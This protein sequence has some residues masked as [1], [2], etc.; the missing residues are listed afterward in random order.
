[1][2]DWEKMRRQINAIDQF[3]GYL[4]DMEG[5]DRFEVSLSEGRY[6]QTSNPLLKDALDRAWDF[7]GGEQAAQAAV[8]GLTCNLNLL[9]IIYGHTGNPLFALYALKVCL[10]AELTPPVWIKEYMQKSV[11]RLLGYAHRDTRGKP[12]D[13]F[14]ESF[15]FRKRGG[16]SGGT[17]FHAFNV[18]LHQIDDV[19]TQMKHRHKN[20]NPSW[21]EA[22]KEIVSENGFKS[23]NENNPNAP[24]SHQTLRKWRSALLKAL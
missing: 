21:K 18:T 1:M 12:D 4:S 23:S 20:R 14:V 11:S 6:P 10:D 13:P 3:L 9:E 17:W 19:L 24:I 2:E 8:E 15:G 16:K 5:W 22:Y 7:D